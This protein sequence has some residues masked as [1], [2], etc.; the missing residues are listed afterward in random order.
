MINLYNPTDLPIHMTFKGTRY[1]IPA[2]SE[3]EVSEEVAEH[4]QTNVH[5]FVQMKP[6]VKK[7]VKT[8]PVEPKK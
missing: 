1:D 8:V 4:W 6:I 2:K 5:H 3:I 7:E